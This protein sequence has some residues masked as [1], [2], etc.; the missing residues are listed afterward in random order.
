MTTK[1]ELEAEY[2]DAR[3]ELDRANLE[4][5]MVKRW[6]R[7]TGRTPEAEDLVHVQRRIRVAQRQV[8]ATE[9]AFKAQGWV[10]SRG[11]SLQDLRREQADAAA[12]GLTPEEWA[13]RRAARE[14]KQREGMQRAAEER[15]RAREAAGFPRRGRPRR[16]A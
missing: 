2:D 11:K 8:R 15:N 1:D 9:N 12:E 10:P 6:A 3:T 13:E 14:A 4:L 16:I 5:F 7:I